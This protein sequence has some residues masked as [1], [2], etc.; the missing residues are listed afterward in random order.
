M[1]V[2]G[3]NEN[4]TVTVFRGSFRTD[5]KIITIDEIDSVVVSAVDV[6]QGGL[7]VDAGLD[8]DHIE[9]G[10]YIPIPT[11][12]APGFVQNFNGDLD[13]DGKFDGGVVTV[14]D[15]INL[16]AGHT[17]NDYVFVGWAFATLGNLVI[18]TGTQNDKIEIYNGSFQNTILAMFGGTSNDNDIA[19]IGCLTTRAIF[20]VDTGIGDDLVSFYASRLMGNATVSTGAGHDTVAAQSY[21]ST[22]VT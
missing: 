2:N 18:N 5:T 14:R 3:N 19:Q 20:S 17:G 11:L 15:D 13:N 8:D 7:A 16:Q 10:L 6:S 9:I 1:T 12:L 21:K 4:D 22:T